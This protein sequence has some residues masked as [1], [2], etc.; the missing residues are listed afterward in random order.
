[1]SG[2]TYRYGLPSLTLD[3]QHLLRCRPNKLALNCDNSRLS[4]IDINGVLSFFD[5]KAEGTG[6]QVTGEHLQYE[7]KVCM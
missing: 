4:V 7:R 5:F 1:M 2:V 6:G 3:Y